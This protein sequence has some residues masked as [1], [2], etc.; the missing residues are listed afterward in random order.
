MTAFHDLVIFSQT[1][2]AVA[3]FYWEVGKSHLQM[4]NL[5][6]NAPPVG[7]PYQ[8]VGEIRIKSGGYSPQLC[9]ETFLIFILV[10]FLYYLFQI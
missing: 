4:R 9:S 7:I 10:V 1:T 2:F 3:Q 8:K 5:N 6:W